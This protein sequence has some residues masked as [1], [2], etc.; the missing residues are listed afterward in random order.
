M[1][2]GRHR[3][4]ASSSST[5]SI[6]DGLP[7]ESLQLRLQ[8]DCARRAGRRSVP[9]RLVGLPRQNASLG[10]AHDQRH[11]ARARGCNVVGGSSHHATAPRSTMRLRSKSQ[12]A[13]V[14]APAVASRP[15]L[16]HCPM[17]R[18]RCDRLPRLKPIKKRQRRRP[19]AGV[20]DEDAAPASL[21][22]VRAASATENVV[23][24]RAGLRAVRPR[25]A[26]REVRT[27]EFGRSVAHEVNRAAALGRSS[28]ARCITRDGNAMKSARMRDALTATCRRRRTGG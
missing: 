17:H 3:C 8:V 23:G 28:D 2:C 1:P 14:E 15:S 5:T 18:A 22:R 21:V 7:G 20:G 19:V 10:L 12:I 24:K 16:A 26:F 25:R 6:T 11:F 13:A 27:G 9:R 4:D